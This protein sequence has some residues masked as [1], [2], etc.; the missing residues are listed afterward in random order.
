MRSLRTASGADCYQLWRWSGNILNNRSY[1]DKSWWTQNLKLNITVYKP[2]RN[3]I[4]NGDLSY[5]IQGDQNSLYT[6]WLQYR[7]LQVMFLPH[8]LPQSDFLATGRQGQGD[9]RL[10][11][12]SSVIYNSKYIIMVSYWNCLKYFCL[13]FY[14]NHQAHRDFL[15]TLYYVHSYVTCFR[16]LPDDPTGLEQ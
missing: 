5:I 12:M 14:R 1:S 7:K 13:F 2:D 9:T 6:W 15:I 11:L 10:T 16:N 3:I 8:Y 4:C